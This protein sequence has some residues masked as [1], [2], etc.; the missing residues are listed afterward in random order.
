MKSDIHIPVL[1]H[2]TL[3]GLNL[4][5]GDV[6]LDATLGFAGHSREIS[7]LIGETG[8]II[9]LDADKQALT[10]ASDVLQTEPAKLFLFN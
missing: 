4:K 5:P 1:L 6:V 8:T 7:R 3:E 9:G 2:Q 10:L